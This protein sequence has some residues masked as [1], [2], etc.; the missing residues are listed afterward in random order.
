MKKLELFEPAMCCS[1]GVCGPSIDEKLL[2]ITSIFEALEDVSQIEASRYNLSSTPDA[3]VK[4][5]AVLKTIQEKG[6]EILPITV[7]DGKIVKTNDYP[8]KEE[9]ADYTG[10]IFVDQSNSEGSC[11]SGSNEC[12]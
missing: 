3:F 4:N 2:T 1:T 6:N 7:L 11:C 5:E 12:C 9:L 8:T 10:L